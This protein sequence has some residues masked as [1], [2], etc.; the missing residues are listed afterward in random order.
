MVPY[1]S[2]AR[3][4]LVLICWDLN[5]VLEA[6][7]LAFVDS[8]LSCLCAVPILEYQIERVIKNRVHTYFI[9]YRIFR[10]SYFIY[11]FLSYSRQYLWIDEKGKRC[12]VAAPQYIDYVM[13]FTQKTINDESI[14]PTK[15]G[16]LEIA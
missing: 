5:L 16:K 13:T 8:L 7:M 3:D 6:G 15:F 4:P 1:P 14:F 11:F 2:F 10:V 9:R 12:K